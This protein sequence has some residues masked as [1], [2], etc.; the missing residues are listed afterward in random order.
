MRAFQYASP[1]T[2][3]EAV[4]LLGTGD[5]AVLAGGTD[6]L[7]LLK[8]DAVTAGRLVNIKNVDELRGLSRL[9]DGGLRAGALVTIDE[10]A[11]STQRADLT[12]RPV[13]TRCQM[14]LQFRGSRQ[15]VQE[16]STA[17][18]PNRP[19]NRS[20]GDASRPTTWH[21]LT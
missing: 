8:D 7:S 17:A 12:A 3:D 11:T 14:L 1:T 13:P 2:V 19:K 16:C 18:S 15:Q 6:L 21:T 10:F 5:A 4:Q 20:I 9:P